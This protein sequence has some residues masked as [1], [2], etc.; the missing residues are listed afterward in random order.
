MRPY[1]EQSPL[2]HE[3][4]ADRPPH[5]VITPEIRALAAEIVGDQ[6]NPLE[7]ARRIFRW[8]SRNIPW[9]GEM[10]YSIIPNLSAK[11]L[12]TRRGDCGV[13]GMTFI[14][15]C[16]AAGVPA[17][18]QSGWQTKPD[19][20]N[21][22]D[23]SEIYIEP[24]GWLPADASNGM[25][26]SDD[27]AVRDF[28]CGHLDAYR[29][30]VNLDYGRE[31]HPPKTS[32]R[33]EPADFQRGE[34]EIDGHNLY[35]D[36]WSYT[37]RVETT[38]LEPGVAALEA[39]LDERVPQWLAEAKIPG[40]VIVV[41]RKTGD[42]FET[43]SKAYGWLRTEPQREPMPLDAV[44]DMASVTKP[45]ATGS[46]LSLLIQRNEVGLDD[47]VGKYLLEFAEGAKAG[48][49]VRQ[50]MTHTSG[51]PPY[52]GAAKQKVVSDK[53][54]YPCPEAIREYIRKLDLQADPG[55]VIYSCLNAIL[56]AQIVERVSGQTL[57]EFAHDNVFAPLEMNH[58][59]FRPTSAPKGDRT[60]R[61]PASGR[62]AASSNAETVAAQTNSPIVPTTRA[63]RAAAT[64]GFLT[65]EVHDP[66]AAMQAGVSGNAGLFSTAADLSRYAQM[67]LNGGE[68]DGVRIFEPDML[69]AM[70]RVQDPG[71]KNTS[72]NLD[73][74]GLLWDLYPAD[75]ERDF[76]YGHTGYTGTAI[77]IYPN[78]G[79]YIIALTN[80][81]HPDDTSKVAEFRRR[82]W[83]TVLATVPQ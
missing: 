28:F 60:D 18:W 58:S 34:I 57:D 77:R 39:A 22:H 68:L 24:W 20:W 1:D 40:A 31:L 54:G 6:T 5:I 7:K 8:V 17:R 9:V 52:V 70:T 42:G 55:T 32:F 74:R 3:F 10:E 26:N 13:Q 62:S 65:G 63:K 36:E 47:P 15:L 14:T 75:D 50:L 27:P 49:T 72:G 37:F 64:D 19:S 56:C 83:E 45:V 67:M 79:V 73:R 12:A 82:L 29:L 66:L 38:P 43:W 41:G 21:M 61:G 69:S 30:I 35:F 16:R 2:Y 4:T 23:W 80:R 11:G 81:V 51:M 44:F 78:R 59:G 48:I 33:S 76:A 71:A 53:A 25:L 46:C